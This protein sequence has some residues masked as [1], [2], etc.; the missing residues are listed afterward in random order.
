M[1]DL[2]N[3][4]IHC[5]GQIN[6][7]YAALALGVYA[8]FGNRLKG[9][10]GGLLARLPRL[11]QVPA[12]PEAP[13]T[14]P[15][16]DWFEKHPYLDRLWERLKEKFKAVPDGKVDEDQLFLKLLEAIKDVEVED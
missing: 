9:V 4:L 10:L 7:L 2:V 12:Q 15:L 16:N 6:P 1:E 11:P 14:D 5:L 13:K 3:A 8:L